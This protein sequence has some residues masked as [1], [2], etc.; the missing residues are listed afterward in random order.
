LP[1]KYEITTPTNAIKTYII[2][3]LKV[4]YM[5]R[6]AGP[7]SGRI[8]LIHCGCVY[9]VKCECALGFIFRFRGD[10][11]PQGTFTLHCIKATIVYQYYS[12]WRCP[13]RVETCRRL[14]RIKLYVFW[15][16]NWCYYFVWYSARTWN[17]LS[18]KCFG[19]Y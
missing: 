8:I 3:F 18:R 12:P 1:P 19:F 10:A 16:I 17:I 15:C 7:S 13:S 14:L 5:F 11:Y 4:S 9:I 2:L 6:P